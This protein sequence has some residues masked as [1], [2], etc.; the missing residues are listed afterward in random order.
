MADTTKRDNL[1]ERHGTGATLGMR[2]MRLDL[3]R[4]LRARKTLILFL[5]QLI[6]VLVA[7]ISLFWGDHDG[8]EFF[9]STIEGVYLPLLVPLAALFFG[10]PTIV[11]EVEGKTITYLTLRPLSR[12]TLWFA[13]LATSLLL[14]VS[15][16]VV[17]VVAFFV[18]C[19]LGSPTG[20]ADAMGLLGSAAASI[21]VGAATYTA[22][23]ALLGVVFTSTLL[24][25]I[26]YYVVFELIFAAVP[27]V[28]VLSIKFHLY[29]LGG[30]DRAE[31]DEEGLRDTLEQLLLDQPMEFDW[32]VGLVVCGIVTAAA[33]L[34]AAAVFRQRQFRV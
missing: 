17:A 24:P 22:V 6:P 33:T 13:K 2:L 19:L 1:P 14:A 5:I 20:I 11:D 31:A 8:L 23:F 10:G 7:A 28:E 25:G 34:I 32:W 18:V 29:T 26:V 21:A 4:K 15:T 3:S 12:A 27:I 30:F 9:E 16:T